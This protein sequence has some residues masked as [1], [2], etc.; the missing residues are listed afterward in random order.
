MA[1]DRTI[2]A[3]HEVRPAQLILH[4]L[5]ALLNPVAQAVQTHHL[6]Q[7]GWRMWALGG[8]L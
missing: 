1:S 8:A 4:L 2:A 6:G 3:H 5:V 7:I